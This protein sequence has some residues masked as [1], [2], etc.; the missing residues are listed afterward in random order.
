MAT[1]ADG[2]PAQALADLDRLVHEPAR[3]MI[4]AV[5]YVVEAGDATFLMSQSGLTWGNLSSHVS[6]LEAAGYVNVEKTFKGKRPN[7]MLALT[8]AG[9]AAV[10]VYKQ[11]MQQVLDGLPD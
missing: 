8:E 3:L 9:R 10:R 7:T 6:K 5:L 4:M 11:H 1:P 2:S